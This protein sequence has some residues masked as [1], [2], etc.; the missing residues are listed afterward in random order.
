MSS[1]TIY[2]LH[3]NG[4]IKNQRVGD[5]DSLMLAVEIERF[6]YTLQPPPNYS[7]QWYWYDNKWNKEPRK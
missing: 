4:S 3:S 6:Q 1:L 2:V 7:E 5:I